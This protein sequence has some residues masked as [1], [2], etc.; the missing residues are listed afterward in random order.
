MN[1][2]TRILKKYDKVLFGPPPEAQDE[3]VHKTIEELLVSK[4]GE[5]F[6]Q[7]ASSALPEAAA[8]RDL[9]VKKI[10]EAVPPIIPVVLRNKSL[11]GAYLRTALHFLGAAKL[12]FSRYETDVRRQANPLG[13]VGLCNTIHTNFEQCAVNNKELSSHGIFIREMTA[14][15]QTTLGLGFGIPND[16]TACKTWRKSTYSLGGSYPRSSLLRGRGLNREQHRELA[17]TG[18][19]AGGSNVTRRGARRARG[20]CHEFLSGT[21]LRGAACIF[22]I[23]RNNI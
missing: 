16:S 7:V 6:R 14:Q 2:A 4:E 17:E 1:Q 20:V 3:E 15:Y 13:V 22:C 12:M 21:C 11:D 9:F 23:V 5:A 19:S 8:R 18:G 10:I